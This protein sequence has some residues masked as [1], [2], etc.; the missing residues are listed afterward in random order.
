MLVN[1]A[2]GFT[3]LVEPAGAVVRMRIHA[4]RLSAGL[5]FVGWVLGSLS[6]F[7][8]LSGQQ[9]AV[10]VMLRAIRLGTGCRYGVPWRVGVLRY[11]AG[12][13]PRTTP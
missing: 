4:V 1:T 5:V 9:E 12:G 3:V 7:K 13:L 2:S 8:C 6:A 10:G 11:P